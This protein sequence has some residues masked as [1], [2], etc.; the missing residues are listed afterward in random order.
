ML[1]K[2]KEP[3]EVKQV[4]STETEKR[5]A[6]KIEER[7]GCGLVLISFFI[8]GAGHMIK[9][10]VGK[11]FIFLLLAIILGA[12][13][14]GIAAIIIAFV[15]SNDIWSKPS[16]KCS[17]CQSVV[18]QSAAVCKHCSARFGVN[19]ESNASEK[20]SDSTGLCPHCGEPIKDKRQ[21]MCRNCLKRF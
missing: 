2:P 8:P 21:T 18:P 15:S 12:F 1:N 13:T 7:A 10:E 17:Q 20:S 11:G 19:V 6:N 4:A 3:L 5:S 9:G 14:F 16:F